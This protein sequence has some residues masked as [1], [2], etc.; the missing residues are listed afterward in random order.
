MHYLKQ[1]NLH[2]EIIVK[3]IDRNSLITKTNKFTRFKPQ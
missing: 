2:L 3:K 1:P